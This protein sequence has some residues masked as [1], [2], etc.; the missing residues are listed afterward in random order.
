MP[1]FFPVRL[2]AILCLSMSDV[3]DD[4]TV[5]RGFEFNFRVPDYWT[6]ACGGASF[7]KV[8]LGVPFPV[9]E[10]VYLQYMSG[11]TVHLRCGQPLREL[12]RE[13]LYCTVAFLKQYPQQGNFQTLAAAHQPRGDS[14]VRSMVRATISFLGDKMVEVNEAHFSHPSNHVPHFPSNV[15]GGVDTFPIFSLEKKHRYQPKY[16]AAVLK[17]QAYV[18]HLG[19]FGFISGPHPGA[20]SDTTTARRYHPEGDFTFL[21][22]LAYISVPHCLPPYGA[23]RCEAS[24][25]CSEFTRIHQWYRART[26]H[27]FA[28][29][30]HFGIIDQTYRGRDLKFLKSCVFVLANLCNIVTATRLPYVPYAPCPPR[31]ESG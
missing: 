31:A 30:H 8:K 16:K 2:A 19:M 23:E 5:P 15:V 28:R 21:A 20:A 7:A 9:L 18:S 17:M 22:D 14:F 6:L 3:A 24:E 1:P 27:A 12:T 29:L 13:F 11:H 25:A 4:F 10:Y 26:E